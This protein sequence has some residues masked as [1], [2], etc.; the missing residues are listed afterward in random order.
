[1]NR[2]YRLSLTL[3]LLVLST[4]TLAAQVK[5]LQR[6]GRL[7][8]NSWLEPDGQ[9]VPGQ[10]LRLT[11]EVRTDSWFTGGTRIAIPEQPGLVILQTEQFASNSS[12]NRGGKSWVIQRWYLDVYPQSSGDF[13]VGPLAL[14]VEVNAGG[15]EVARGEILA[16]PVEFSVSVPAALETADFWV[17]SPQFTVE[18]RF[19]KSLEALEPGDAFTRT[20]EFAASDVMAMMLPTF[21]E[22]SLPGLA[23]YPAPPVLDNRSNRGQASASKVQSISYVVESPGN[24]RLPEQEFFWW[25]TTAGE[26]KLLSLPATELFIAGEPTVVNEQSEPLLTPKQWL[27]GL[28]ALAVVALTLWLVLRLSPQRHVSRLRAKFQALWKQ[29]RDLTKPGL[30]D[31]LNPFR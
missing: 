15:L 10:K 27:W 4:T 3:L 22:E 12:E 28:A 5:D 24:Y 29:L 16:P 8:V 26:L 19:D 25:D 31:Q 7:S 9:L 23:A 11:L 14:T 17:A 2:L 18:Q 13:T 6:E 20:I 1:M 21:A 30:P